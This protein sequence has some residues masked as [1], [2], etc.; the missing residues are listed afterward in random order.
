LL[1]AAADSWWFLVGAISS[2]R[3]HEARPEKPN[4]SNGNIELR[5][6]RQN[7]EAIGNGQ[8]SSK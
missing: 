1:F 7:P 6:D 5:A 3:I 4:R 2:L 8:S